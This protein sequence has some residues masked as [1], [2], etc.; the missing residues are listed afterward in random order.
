MP[1]L[2]WLERNICHF[3]LVF[4]L[5]CF[6]TLPH[7]RKELKQFSIGMFPAEKCFEGRKKKQ[8]VKEQNN[9]K[10]TQAEQRGERSGVQ[11]L[12]RLVTVEPIEDDSTRWTVMTW[13]KSGSADLEKCTWE[14]C[15]KIC[16]HWTQMEYGGLKKKR[17]VKFLVWLRSNGNIISQAETYGVSEAERHLCSDEEV[18]SDPAV[19]NF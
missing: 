2:I 5:F 19:W 10:W 17:T 15:C 9:D 13:A 6:H 11:W 18:S 4:V 16:N 12:D 14:L 8:E 3:Y 7:P 1:F